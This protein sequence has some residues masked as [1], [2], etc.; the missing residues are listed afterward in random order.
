M[1]QYKKKD[2][3]ISERNAGFLNTLEFN[4]KI[5]PSDV[6]NMAVQL[7]SG[8][9]EELVKD[10][11]DMEDVKEALTNSLKQE[12]YSQVNAKLYILTAPDVKPE[13]SLTSSI[14][15]GPSTVEING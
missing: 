12:S 3:W 13:Q 15:S 8:V 6:V 1:E 4:L 2:Y 9:S 14:V 5:R 11:G 10:S 7:L